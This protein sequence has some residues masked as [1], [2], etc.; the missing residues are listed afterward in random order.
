MKGPRQRTEPLSFEGIRRRSLKERR[1]K[2]VEGDLAIPYRKGS[3]FREFLDSLPDI[4]GAKALRAIAR[5]IVEARKGGR[6]VILGMG[7]HVIK[8]GLSPVI[9]DLMEEG[10]IT[11]VAMNGAGIV[12]DFEMAYSGTTSEDVDT[13]IDEGMFGMT[14]ETGRVINEAIKKGVKDGLG[15]GEALG[16]EI[17]GSSCPHKELSILAT[18]IRLN[19]PVTVH[20]A[21]GTDVVHF[22]PEADGWAIGEGSMI[23]FRIFC[24]MVKDL[25]GG[26]YLNIGSAV[27]LPEVFLKAITVVRNLGHRVERFTTV[28][29]DFIRHYRPMTNVVKRP[30]KRGG[31]GYHLTGHHEIMVPLLVAAMKEAL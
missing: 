24:G 1:S 29:M 19:I 17:D 25:E 8:T 6:P 11:G 10:M 30:T 28:N 7:A 26:V 23:D 27:I 18:G 21:I 16:R 5:H 2:V 22:H 3:S 31:R 12:H 4:L 15:I 13:E 20:V 14:E 9:I